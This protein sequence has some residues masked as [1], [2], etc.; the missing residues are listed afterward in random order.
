MVKT[1]MTNQSSEITNMNLPRPLLYFVDD[2]VDLLEIYEDRFSRYFD[3]KCFSSPRRLIEEIRT[4]ACRH[5]DVIVTD[6]RMAELD[7]L[8]MLREL[9]NIGLQSPAIL[10][11]GNLDQEA[12]ELAAGAGVSRILDKPVKETDLRDSIKGLLPPG[13][14]ADIQPP[15][16][17]TRKSDS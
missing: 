3:I 13:K 1:N 16:R 2:E 6:L 11:S 12:A 10:L 9:R 14:F 15:V 8:E 7:G 17:K 5:P 4:N